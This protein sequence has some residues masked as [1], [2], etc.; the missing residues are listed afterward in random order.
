MYARKKKGRKIFEL[1]RSKGPSEF[2]VVSRARWD[3]HQRMLVTQEEKARR[4]SDL[5]QKMFG[6]CETENGTKSQ[7]GRHKKRPVKSAKVGQRST[8]RWQEEDVEL[9]GPTVKL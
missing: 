8:K 7:D 4:S 6:P 3:E 9:L 2:L 5:V 1:F